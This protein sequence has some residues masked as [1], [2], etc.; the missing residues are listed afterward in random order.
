MV[1]KIGFDPG[2]RKTG[3]LVPMKYNKNPS[4]HS[5]RNS[6][7]FSSGSESILISTRVFCSSSRRGSMKYISRSRYST[8]N[9]NSSRCTLKMMRLH[10]SLVR[11]SVAS[12]SSELPPSDGAWI[13][14]KVVWFEV[15]V[16]N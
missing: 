3:R 8:R 13:S 2:Q 4:G 1:L 7:S 14:V 6:S 9:V 16:L 12:L 5:I 15:E 11:S 10:R